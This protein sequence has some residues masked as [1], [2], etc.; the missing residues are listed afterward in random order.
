MSCGWTSPPKDLSY[1]YN[2]QNPLVY[3]TKLQ[4]ENKIR[5]TPEEGPENK[6]LKIEHKLKR[7]YFV[8]LTRFQSLIAGGDVYACI[9]KLE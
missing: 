3:Q 7:E 9:T 1:Q 4:L 5:I 8:S 6:L 2:N